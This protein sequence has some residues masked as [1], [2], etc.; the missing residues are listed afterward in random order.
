MNITKNRFPIL[1][2]FSLDVKLA[3]LLIRTCCILHNLC[4]S[5]MDEFEDENV[6]NEENEDLPTIGQKARSTP[7]GKLLRD[8][9][10]SEQ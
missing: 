1:L 8:L 4:V 2:A 5:D 3:P 9:L 6:P 10:I 7:V